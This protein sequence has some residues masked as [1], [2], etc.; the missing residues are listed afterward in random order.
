MS[1]AEGEE[2]F[3]ALTRK[4]SREAGLSLDAYKDKCLRRRIAVRMRASG[5]HSYADYQALLDRDPEEYARLKDTITINVTRFYRNVETWELIR[6]TVLPQVCGVA[7][8]EIRAWSAGC[9]SGEEP[10]TLAMLIAEHLESQG[11]A[12]RLDSVTVDATDIDRECLLRARA[13][14]YRPETLSDVPASLAQRYFEMAGGEYQVV[15]RVRRRVMVRS[16]DLCADPP[17]A[18]SY[19]LILCRNV[20]IY[21]ERATQDRIFATFANALAPGGF[22]ILG[23]VES[24]SG[25]ARNQLTLLDAR[26]RIYRR[27]A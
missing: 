25:Q 5:A 26:E 9:A 19:D 1:A 18:R 14:R 20:V 23:K 24:L 6:T 2:A 13:A 7:R 8:G 15:E 4:I 16:G 3:L 27:A 22:L 10:Y 21:F 17:P 11:R 12:E